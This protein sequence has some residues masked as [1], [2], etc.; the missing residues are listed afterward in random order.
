[1]HDEPAVAAAAESKA[2][3]EAR[4]RAETRHQEEKQR[5]LQAEALQRAEKEQLEE[6]RRRDLEEQRRAEAE[7]QHL[8]AEV[9][10]A[11]EQKRI[12]TEE[13]RR[14][15]ALK[16]DDKSNSRREV[17]KEFNPAVVPAGQTSI[18]SQAETPAPFENTAKVSRVEDHETEHSLVQS[19]AEEPLN[20]AMAAQTETLD[21]DSLDANDT[22]DGSSDAQRWE[23]SGPITSQKKRTRWIVAV[24]V[25]VGF[26]AVIGIAI[27]STDGKLKENPRPAPVVSLPV[28]PAGMVYIPGGEF[29]MGNSAGDD[30]EKP[31][32]KVNVKPFFMDIHEVTCDDYLKFVASTATGPRVRRSEPTASPR[33]GPP[34]RQQAICPAGATQTPATGMDW[35]DASAYARWAKKRL[36]TEEEW[37]FAARGM[38]ARSYP[39]GNEWKT[40]AA[41]VGS[42]NRSLV[43]VGSFPDGKSSAGVMD[44]IG[45]AWEWTSSDMTAYPNG[46]IPALPPGEFKVIRGG[47]W[48]EDRTQATSTYR[49]FLLTSGEKDYSATGIRCVQDLTPQP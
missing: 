26:S 21:S 28:A 45:N 14:E 22:S 3:E 27:F 5:R 42:I 19:L 29:L 34:R 41:N 2:K 8:Q 40:N 25:I 39:W 46:H 35:N 37:E 43:D 32:H 23:Y 38:D 17:E 7:Q 1:M 33:G 36:P 49:G 11:A 31:A 30:F 16:A 18:R 10:R 15:S 47:S 20:V 48:K 24:V 4:L 44:L 13:Q 6:K 12:R 9:D